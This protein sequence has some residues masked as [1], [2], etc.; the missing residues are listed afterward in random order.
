[1]NQNYKSAFITL[2]IGAQF[3]ACYVVRHN[4]SHL[5]NA[6][7]GFSSDMA[8]RLEK[9]FG[10]SAGVC[11]YDFVQAMTRENRFN[12]KGYESV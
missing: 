8:I 1:M 12:I 10:L 2:I 6:Q 9:S 3:C 5:I 11:A 4:I 7:A